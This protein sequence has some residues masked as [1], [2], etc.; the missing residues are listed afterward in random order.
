MAR[1]EGREVLGYSDRAD[2]R[3]AAAVGDAKGLVQVEVADV[4]ANVARGGQADLR[5]GSYKLKM[6]RKC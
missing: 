4:G 3:A 2:A 6:V 5:L 1:E